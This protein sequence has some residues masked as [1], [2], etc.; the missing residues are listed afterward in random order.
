[1]STIKTNRLQTLNGD[2]FN[3]PVQVVRS[4]V[5]VGG[6]TS[7]DLVNDNASYALAFTTTTWT[8]IAFLQLAITPKF[9][10]SVIR[11][12][13]HYFVNNSGNSNNAALRIRRD[14]TIIW[15]PQRNATGPY[16]TGHSTNSSLYMMQPLVCYDTPNTVNPITYVLQYRAYSSGSTCR[17][18]GHPGS[19]EYAPVVTFAAMEF[20]Q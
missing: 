14:T 16:G 10:N 18:F 15:Q 12:E 4:T 11:L 1:M 6:T 13:L 3:L 17:L 20:A 7:S 2:T 19:G 5:G 9:V 8:D